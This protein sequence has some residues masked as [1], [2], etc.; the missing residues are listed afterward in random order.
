M[1][2]YASLKSA[3][4]DGRVLILAFKDERTN[5]KANQ[6]EIE[7]SRQDPGRFLIFAFKDKRTNKQAQRSENK[8]SEPAKF[9]R[10]QGQ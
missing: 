2:R 7:I 4:T 5:A 6:S 10:A 3:A 9:H 8:N 1:S